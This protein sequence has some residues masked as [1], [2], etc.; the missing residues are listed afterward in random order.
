MTISRPA[1]A[2]AILHPPLKALRRWATA[3][4]TPTPRTRRARRRTT[5]AQPPAPTPSVW[6]LDRA[7]LTSALEHGRW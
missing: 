7:E 2:T 5:L 6:E 4:A 3:L 1:P